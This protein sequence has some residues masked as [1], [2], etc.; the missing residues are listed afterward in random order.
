[1]QIDNLKGLRSP[2][3]FKKPLKPLLL[4]P[5]DKKERIKRYLMGLFFENSLKEVRKERL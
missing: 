5:L 4:T 1:M 2:N 3:K